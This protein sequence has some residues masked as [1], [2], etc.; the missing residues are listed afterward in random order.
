MQVFILIDRA[1]NASCYVLA[2]TLAT[3]LLTFIVHFYTYNEYTTNIQE[4]ISLDRS[5]HNNKSN[6][7]YLLSILYSN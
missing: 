6:Y 5:D 3:L 1:V 7:V 4:L 2:Y